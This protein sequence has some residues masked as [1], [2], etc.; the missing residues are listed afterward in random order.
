MTNSWTAQILEDPEDPE[1]LI[2]Q[3]PDDMLD[4]LAWQPG[5]T[6]VWDLQDDGSIILRKK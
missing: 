6:L 5:D 3:F 2:L 4:Q 1:S